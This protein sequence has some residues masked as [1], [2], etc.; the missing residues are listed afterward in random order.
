MNR[1]RR[2][3]RVSVSVCVC[4]CV[5]VV[6]SEPPTHL[7]LLALAHPPLQEKQAAWRIETLELLK[8]V[9]G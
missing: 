9:E 5:C 6:P 7:L 8:E 3:A 4:L 1:Q 2:Q